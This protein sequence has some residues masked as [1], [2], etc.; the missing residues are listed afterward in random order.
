MLI[1][2]DTSIDLRAACNTPPKVQWNAPLADLREDD[3]ILFL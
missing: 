1:K 3:L 2:A